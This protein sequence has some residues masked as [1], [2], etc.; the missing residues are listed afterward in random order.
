VVMHKDK[1]VPNRDLLHF[2][3]RHLRSDSTLDVETFKQAQL[4]FRQAEVEETVRVLREINEGRGDELFE[5]NSRGEGRHLKHWQ[6][7]LAME[8]VTIGGHSF[9]A[10]LALQTL[11]SGPQVALPFGGAVVLDPG[12]HSGPLNDDIGVSTLIV[13]SNSWSRPRSMFFGR[14][15][16]DVVK[17][18]VQ[19][20]LD[21]GKAAWFMT[22]IGTSHPSVTDAPL[23]EP[24]LLRWATGS[25]IDAHEGVRQYVKV[26]QRF[27]QY[28]STGIKA[29]LLSECVT[30]LEYDEPVQPPN[31][32][33]DETKTMNVT[34]SALFA[35]YWQIHAA[36]ASCGGEI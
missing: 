1:N 23:I 33:D 20:I 3:L 32:D 26:S 21:G 14:P 31:P 17:G 24:L 2:S 29:G 10:T 22:S 6:G 11:K 9:G 25:T 5:L 28:Q 7:R 27:L 35:E 36:P 13:H 30:H 19:K 4:D 8:N 15:H 34:D 18:L 16:F 12:K